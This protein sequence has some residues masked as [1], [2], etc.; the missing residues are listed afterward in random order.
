M[1]GGLTQNKA[2]GRN[3]RHRTGRKAVF[4]TITAGAFLLLMA[5]PE[6]AVGSVK[7]GLEICAFSAIPSLFPFMVLSELI[8]SSGVAAVLGKTLERPAKALFGIT[9]HGAT[10]VIL[11]IICGFPIGAKCCASM[12]QKGEMTEK[13]VEHTLMLCNNPSSAFIISAVGIS[14]FGSKSFGVLLYSSLLLSSLIV[15]LLG[16]WVLKDKKQDK[17]ALENERINSLK[18]VK[19]IQ[20]ID[21]FSL[22]TDAVSSSAYGMLTVCAYILFFSALT[23]A[24]GSITEFLPDTI[25]AMFVGIF[26]MTNG[27]K[28][29][30]GLNGVRLPCI[31]AAFVCGWSG[32]SVHLQIRSI[33]KN[34]GNISFLPYITAKLAQAVIAS[35]AVAI[36]MSFDSKTYNLF[37][38][39]EASYSGRIGSGLTASLFATALFVSFLTELK[40]SA[41]NFSKKY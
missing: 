8:V 38:Y 6:A 39:T 28:Q 20:N 21:P 32:V 3:T 24:V 25:G 16:K 29:V 35:F 13:E 33:C 10:A 26:E 22:F 11:G 4:G 1:T 18:S 5:V 30:S 34:C 15:G 2:D 36:A 14:M 37:R 27:V 7:K 40:R 41:K 17:N 23:G 31:M 19:T 12:Y 9:G